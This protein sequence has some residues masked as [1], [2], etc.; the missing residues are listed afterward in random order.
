MGD[1]DGSLGAFKVS[2]GLLID[3]VVSEGKFGA[4]GSEETKK[5]HIQK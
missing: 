2:E 3:R 4:E 5:C 1:R